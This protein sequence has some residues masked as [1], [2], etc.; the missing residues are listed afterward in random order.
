MGQK[1]KSRLFFPD[2]VSHKHP[3]LR[4]EVHH[5][6]MTST[7]AMGAVGGGRGVEAHLAPIGHHLWMGRRATDLH[8]VECRPIEDTGVG[9]E[10]EVAVVVDEGDTEHGHGRTHDLAA[11]RHG[12]ACRAL[13]TVGHHPE[14]HPDEVGE[15][16]MEG[17]IVRHG[18]E[19]EGL[20]AE[21][22]EVQ[23]TAPMAAT[24]VEAE[25]ADERH[26][27]VFIISWRSLEAFARSIMSSI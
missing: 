4:V 7:G 12:E 17:G 23:A 6:A 27:F 25:T 10:A 20:E 16:A 21:E 3:R 1:F 14:H 18:G 11:G 9:V 2:A 8:R 19:V 5:R 13:L 26:K 15:G 24:G 22:G